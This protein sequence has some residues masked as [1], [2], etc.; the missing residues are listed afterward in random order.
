MTAQTKK[1]E[2]CT[3]EETGRQSAI[4]H[5]IDSVGCMEEALCHILCAESAKINAVV[6]TTSVPYDYDD[7]YKTDCKSTSSDM[8]CP[9]IDCYLAVNKSVRKMVK[10]ITILEVVL[11]SKL[12]LFEKCICSDEHDKSRK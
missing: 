11:H 7:D 8:M 6:D 10:S 5:V 9:N 12:E 2:P 3:P 4:T 1:S